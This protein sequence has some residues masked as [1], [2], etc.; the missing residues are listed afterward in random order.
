MEKIG[1]I[2]ELWRYPVSSTAGERVEVLNVTPDGI[3]HERDYG[4]VEVASG[5]ISDPGREERWRPTLLVQTRLTGDGSAEIRVPGGAWHGVLSEEAQRE[6]SAFFG[7]E[8]EV[9]PYE[10][11]QPQGY[12][13]RLTANRYGPSP[14]HVLTTAS[15]A[16]LGRLHPNGVADARRFR[17]NIVIDMQPVAGRFPE[18]EWIGGELTVGA[19]QLAITEPTRRCGLTILGQEGVPFDPEILRQLV[20]NNGHNIGVYCRPSKTADLKVGDE[21][22][23]IQA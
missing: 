8:V 9:R 21:V 16:E 20:R 7:F 4:I 11:R 18:T 12:L 6:L 15:L 3:P 17:P 13:G 10:G 1:T 2:I 19:L 5:A 14:L 22:F 23:L